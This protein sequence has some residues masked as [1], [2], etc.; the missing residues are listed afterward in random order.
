MRK[1]KHHFFP[2]SGTLSFKGAVGPRAATRPEPSC[3]SR[4]NVF[5]TVLSAGARATGDTVRKTPV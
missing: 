3:D 2:F 1:L 5:H 4:N